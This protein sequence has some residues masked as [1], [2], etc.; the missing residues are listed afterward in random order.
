MKQLSS[1]LTSREIEE[2]IRDG[3]G[4][5]A[6][7]QAVAIESHIEDCNSCRERLLESSRQDL[8]LTLEV[9]QEAGIEP[10][11]TMECPDEETLIRFSAGVIA[12]EELQ[13]TAHVARCEY[14]AS[15][16]KNYLE[17]PEEEPS[18]P[19]KWGSVDLRAAMRR[20]RGLLQTKVLVP[21]CAAALAIGGFVE[22]PAI[23]AGYKLNRANKAVMAAFI[24]QRPNELRETWSPYAPYN[25]PLGDDQDVLNNPK[26]VAAMNSVAQEGNSSDPRWIRIRGQVELLRK[27]NQAVDVLTRARAAGLDDPATEIDLA[28]AY[29]QR[30]IQM[31]AS[32][33]VEQKAN[34]PSSGGTE[35]KNTYPQ[36]QDTLKLLHNV[37]QD[38]RTTQEQRAVALFDLAITY[39]KSQRRDEAAR[40][41][42]DYLKIDSTSPWA[43]EARQHQNSDKQNTPPPKQQGYREPVFFCPIPQILTSGKA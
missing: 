23:V 3:Y 37:L 20:I 1:H 24:H 21:A 17:D 39:E 4:E 11:R 33:T 15:K 14:C 19:F 25:P 27:R 26:L 13:L 36:L 40:T 42:D 38:P 18:R 32:K 10:R 12:D 2:Y 41:W 7:P 22:G 28:A 35:D 29:F 31:A 43:E 34:P 8:R 5:N 16:V 30:E 6:S 9:P